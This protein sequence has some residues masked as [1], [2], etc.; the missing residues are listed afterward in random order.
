L[1]GQAREGQGKII[2]MVPQRLI[3]DNYPGWKKSI[4]SL[5][6]CINGWPSLGIDLVSHFPCRE[7]PRY[8][9]VWSCVIISIEFMN[10]T[11]NVLIRFQLKVVFTT[12]GPWEVDAYWNN[13]LL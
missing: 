9:I 13:R 7:S 2:D 5:K 10:C 3:Y 8:W 1:H 11:F 6:H 4:I 12:V